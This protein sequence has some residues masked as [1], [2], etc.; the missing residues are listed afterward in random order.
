M[1]TVIP[2]DAGPASFLSVLFVDPSGDEYLIVNSTG[3][4]DYLYVK[5]CD[6]KPPEVDQAM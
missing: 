2:T 3:V 1:L 6:H 4:R 5:G